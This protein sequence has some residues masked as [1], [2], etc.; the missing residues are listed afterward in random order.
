MME[1]DQHRRKRFLSPCSDDGSPSFW[2]HKR[3]SIIGIDSTHS[4]AHQ[5]YFF[6]YILFSPFFHRNISHNTARSSSRM[7]SLP[8]PRMGCPHGNCVT[9]YA[10]VE[11]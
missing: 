1:F 9:N 4:P 2:V 5:Q 10:H 11:K 8:T 7:T 3:M 6:P